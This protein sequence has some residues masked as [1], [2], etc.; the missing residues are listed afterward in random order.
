MLT[1]YN[2]PGNVRE[3]ENSIDRA[4][5]V[6][7]DGIILPSDLPPEIDAR[8][9]PGA[10]TGGAAAAPRGGILDDRPTLAELER[11]YID[12][13]LAECGGNKKK[14]AER[15]GIDRRTLYRALERT[16]VDASDDTGDDTGDD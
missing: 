10:D 14:A 12:L 2:W 15:L 6:A 4:V 7:K 8:R 3:L 9:R 16:G 5:A 1:A 11:R 13:V